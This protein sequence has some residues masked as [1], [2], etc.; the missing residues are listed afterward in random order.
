MS[1]TNN[2]YKVKPEDL[3]GEIEGFPIE[4]VQKMVDYQVAQGN[5]ADI[6]IFQNNNLASKFNKGF[7]WL[8]TTEESYWCDIIVGREFN[9]FFE[10]DPKE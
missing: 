2:T 5:K 6:T 9:I 3:I 7:N 4:I 8:E 10:D 1:E